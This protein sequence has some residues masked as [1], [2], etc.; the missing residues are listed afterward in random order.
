MNRIKG[1]GWGCLK[2]D[3][4][5]GF[6]SRKFFMICR[7]LHGGFKTYDLQRGQRWIYSPPPEPEPEPEPEPDPA[8][9]TGRLAF[10]A[11]VL[12]P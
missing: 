1:I 9:M 12:A 3:L 2:S 4:V 8:S 6:A 10:I 7:Y 5:T 11:L